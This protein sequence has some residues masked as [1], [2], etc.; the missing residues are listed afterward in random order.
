MQRAE[1]WSRYWSQGVLHSCGGSFEGD[2]QGPIAAF[3]RA[4]FEALPP[5]ARVLDI[6]T[7]NGP[8]PKLLLAMEQRSDLQ[9]DAIDLA[10]ITPPWLAQ[11]PAAAQ[12]R[13]RFHGGC[14]AERLP[15]P[16]QCFQLVISQWGLEYSQLA[17]SVP[18]ILRVLAP[19]AAVRLLLHHVQALPV[20]LAAAELEHLDWLMA[21]EGFLDLAKAMVAPMA[22]AGRPA[23]RARLQGDAAAN[24]LRDRFNL[25]QDALQARIDQGECPDVLAET[26]DAVSR[27]LVQATREGAVAAHAGEQALRRNLLDSRV[28]LQE[29]RAHALDE[30]AAAS[31]G[32]AL[33]GG[34]GGYELGVLEER[35]QLM[36]WTLV[37]KPRP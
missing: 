17:L 26:R 30:A 21:P 24:A 20:V 35:G 33:A 10:R 13:L 2:Y 12:A 15:F 6:A 25:A 18:E 9:C 36:G 29:L 37:V 27:L 16:D 11:Q 31:L 23:G 4:G 28:R 19:G 7:G 3:W 14:A 34:A 1:L 22:L 32:E 5:D 8:L